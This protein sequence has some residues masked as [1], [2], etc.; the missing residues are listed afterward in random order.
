[1]S[2]VYSRWLAFYTRYLDSA[3]L[4]KSEFEVLF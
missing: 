3:V 4:Y 2:A 1:M